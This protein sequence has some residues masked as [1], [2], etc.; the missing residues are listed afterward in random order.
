MQSS[1]VVTFRVVVMLACLV[2]VPLLAV[3]GPSLAKI[4]R[5]LGWW[6]QPATTFQHP[7]PGQRE[8]RV[9]PLAPVA[10]STEF[11]QHVEATPPASTSIQA[12][13]NPAAQPPGDPLA[14]AAQE[15]AAESED[16][17][18]SA[19][20]RLTATAYSP[21]SEMPIHGAE[22]HERRL[23]SEEAPPPPDRFAAAERRLR[24]LGATYYLLEAWGSEGNLYR[25]QCRMAMAA[26]PGYTRH[27]EATDSNPASAIEGVIKQVEAWHAGH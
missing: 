16:T 5:P 19:P 22:A 24:E 21:S 18:E 8:G 26:S 17:S 3:F 1:A 13:P 27:F 10:E 23:A 2:A 7:V 20:P 6:R 15:S 9:L 25:F 11:S 4:A 14:T 12:G